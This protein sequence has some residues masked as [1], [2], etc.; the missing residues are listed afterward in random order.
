MPRKKKKPLSFVEKVTRLKKSGLDHSIPIDQHRVN[1]EELETV[2]ERIKKILQLSKR[3]VKGDHM[4]YFIM[5]DVEDN[6]VRREIFKYLKDKG[7][8]HIQKSIFLASSKRNAF[9]EIH[10][11]LK[12]INSMYDNADSILM[13]PVASDELQ[14]MKVIGLNIDLDLILENRSTMFF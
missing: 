9:T 13:V 4:L 5:Y 7:C 6:K 2:N 1:L 12:D 14:A 11:A 8:L 10:S 3:T